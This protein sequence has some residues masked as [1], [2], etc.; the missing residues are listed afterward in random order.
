MV[1]NS[2][3]AVYIQ[4][5]L[6]FISLGNIR[7]RFIQFFSGEVLALIALVFAAQT[8][9]GILPIPTLV[10]F[11]LGVAILTTGLITIFLAITNFPPFYEFEWKEGLSQFLVINPLDNT[12]LFFYDFSDPYREEFKKKD[13]KYLIGG[14]KGLNEII[15]TI[16]ASES[17][18]LN[19]IKFGEHFILQSQSKN[20]NLPLQYALIVDRDLNSYRHILRELQEQFEAFFKEILSHFEDLNTKQEQE[21][22]FLSFDV[23]INSLMEN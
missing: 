23:I 13:K 19:S 3:Y 6:I 16:T 9:F 8:N 5:R 7:K 14:L 21:Q 12:L 10:T 20:Q 22:I 4:L 1:L 2:L 15:D 18:N 11:Y 17:K